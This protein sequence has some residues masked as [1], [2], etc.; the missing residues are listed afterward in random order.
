M[1]AAACDGDEGARGR[2][3]REYAPVLLA[4]FGA[5][6]RAGTLRGEVDDAVQE[7]L[8][9]CLRDGGA[10][11][12]ADRE[13]SFRPFL[14][15]VARTVA[16]RFEERCGLG[17]ALELVDESIEARETRISVAFDRAYAVQLMREATDLQSTK[18]RRD[19]GAKLRRFELLELRFQHGRTIAQIAEQWSEDPARVHHPY[20]D[21][22]EDF[23]SALV[24]II[25][26]R[27]CAGG[28]LEREC[29]W[30]LQVLRGKND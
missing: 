24:E 27:G 16:L 28:D 29:D 1:I 4:Y 11:A 2:F 19:G 7:V 14:S 18:A 13:R 8:M 20:A 23:R 5:R 30:M 9:D 3:A 15:G 17:A 26:G 22:R 12:R 6:W 21:A 25:R 10:L